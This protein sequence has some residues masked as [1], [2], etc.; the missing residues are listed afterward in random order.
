MFHVK[1][2]R[3]TRTQ[4]TSVPETA[5]LALT[6]DTAE[7]GALTESR[8]PVMPPAIPSL[9][10]GA[11]MAVIQ[12]KDESQRRDT[13]KGALLGRGS[14]FEGKLTFEGTVQ[15]DGEF[16]GDI[17]SE[18]ELIVGET[19]K[20][21]GTMQVSS[22]S[23]SGEVVGTITTT[24]TLELRPTARVTGELNVESLVVARGAYFDGQ[25]KMTG[26]AT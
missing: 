17:S 15:I 14:K 19:A 24:G 2:T 26:R 9:T 3:K 5:L 21:E 7:T 6:G 1:R 22:A 23:I 20:I 8:P 11:E 10:Q 18:G 16:Y 13:M 4:V 25:V 12:M